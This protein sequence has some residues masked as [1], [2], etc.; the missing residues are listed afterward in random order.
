MLD[1][2]R[3]KGSKLESELPELPVDVHGHTM[4]VDRIVELLTD[5][6]TKDVAVVL[7]SG[8]PGIGK[9]TVS[10]QA[11]H[12]LKDDFGRIV[13]FCSL[14]D[15][16]PTKNG[17]DTKDDEGERVWREI[18][19]K[20]QPDH[21]P[22]KE[23]PKYA[24]LMWCRQLEEDL[25]LVLDNA[26]DAQEDNFKDSFMGLL[27]EMRTCSKKKIKFIITSRRTDIES[28]GP[29]LT[30]EK[31]TVEPLS[32][33]DSIQVLKGVGRLQVD[34]NVSAE[35]L[36]KIAELCEHI[37]IVLRLASRLLSSDSEYSVDK[38]ID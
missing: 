33:K 31:V 7:V 8:M 34:S 38:L 15:L 36:R 32:E 21:L 25:V 30:V 6:S 23:Y 37:P 28:T 24:L 18:L 17:R 35:K 9:S 1:A 27:T 19:S 29:N 10:L 14:R 11:G 26:E 4:E 20:C 2:G 22:A 3:E 5:D 12:K 16:H 13:K